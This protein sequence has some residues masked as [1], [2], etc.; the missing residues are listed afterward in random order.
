MSDRLWSCGQMFIPPAYGR[1]GNCTY[2]Y[3]FA[4][5]ICAIIAHWA[6]LFP[7]RVPLT[8]SAHHGVCRASAETVRIKCGRL[9]SSRTGLFDRLTFRS[10][11]TREILWENLYCRF[12]STDSVANSIR[13]TFRLWFET[14]M[15]LSKIQLNLPWFT[16][17]LPPLWLTC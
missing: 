17:W 15:I 13:S 11:S 14:R 8:A 2:V 9:A 4:F 1:V 10:F 3:I 12:C 6:H 5:F 7:L 16:F